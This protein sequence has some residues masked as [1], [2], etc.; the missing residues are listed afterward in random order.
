[1]K[2]VIF[3]L[4]G[5]L[6]DSMA[7]W[8]CAGSNYLRYKGIKSVDNVDNI[9]KSMSLEEAARFFIKNYGFKMTIKEIINEVNEFI[10]DRYRYGFELKNGVLDYL[11]Y[12]KK[13]KVKMC[14]AT[15]TDSNLACIALKRLGVDEY[16]E[17]VLSCDEV[18]YN[19]TYPNIYLESSKRMG[20]NVEDITVFEDSLES[21]KTA[22]KAGFTVVGV[23]DVFER[24]VDLVRRICDKYI[25]SFNEM[26]EGK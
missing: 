4:D 14:I 20:V 13:N 6:I 11:K 7:E 10:S 3:D 1:M 12:L 23:H 9:L 8:E 22:K 15:M 21:I 18:G 24:R 16:F 26:L 5:T 17:F 2:A 25:S 19:K